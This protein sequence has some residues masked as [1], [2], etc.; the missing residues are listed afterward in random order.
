MNILVLEKDGNDQLDRWCEKRCLKKSKEGKNVLERVKEGG[1]T[2]LV[3]SC[4]ET[5]F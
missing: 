2:V 5:T 1:P 4:V 3:I